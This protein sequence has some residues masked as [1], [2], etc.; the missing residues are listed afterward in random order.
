KAGH[1]IVAVYSQ[2]P[3]PAHRGKTV[4]HC[5]VHAYADQQGLPVLTPLKLRDEQVKQL[6]E[7]NPDIIVVVAYGL[8]LPKGFLETPKYGCI[9][10]HPSLLPRWRGAAPI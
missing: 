3:R 4:T 9:N 8:I 6:K 1:E 2:P 5:P 7:L 10:V